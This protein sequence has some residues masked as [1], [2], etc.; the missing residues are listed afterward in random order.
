MR[1]WLELSFILHF[2][3]LFS[4]H[5]EFDSIYQDFLLTHHG[6]DVAPLNE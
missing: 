1:R 5:A 3:F 2:L 6:I 4:I